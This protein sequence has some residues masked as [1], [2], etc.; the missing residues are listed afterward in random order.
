[1]Y[2][3]RVITSLISLDTRSSW[4]NLDYFIMQKFD[5]ENGEFQW[6]LDI[7][8]DDDFQITFSQITFNV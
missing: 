7:L 1:M 5:L 4:E 2:L 8:L 3:V 6:Y